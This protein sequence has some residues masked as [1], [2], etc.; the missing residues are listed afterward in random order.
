PRMLSTIAVATDGSDTAQRAV[1]AAFDLAEHYDAPVVVLTA[2][3]PGRHDSIGWH[4]TEATQAERV[5]A[6]ASEAAEARGVRC[7]TAM[8]EGDPADAIVALAVERGADLLVVGN[9]G[10]ERRLRGS[11]PDTISHRAQCSVFVVKTS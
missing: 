9:K 7:S 5:L 4:A 11:V 1:E 6:D 10:M 8:R 2:Y 3:A